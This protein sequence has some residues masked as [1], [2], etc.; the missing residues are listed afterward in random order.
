M[1]KKNVRNFFNFW[2]KSSFLLAVLTLLF[3]YTTLPETIAFKHNSFGRPIGY[4]DKQSFFYIAVGILL[5]FN[6]I[7][8]IGKNTFSSVDWAKINPKS[9]W[10]GAK[11][12]LKSIVKGWFDAFLAIVNSMLVFVFLGLNSINREVDKALDR[13]YDWVLITIAIIFMILVFFLPLK[14]LF[15]KP[16]ERT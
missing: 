2:R 3:V 8:G 14:L 7:L 5:L 10:A 1:F 11:E 12:S 15:D 13:N 9:V 4:I 16:K 6:L